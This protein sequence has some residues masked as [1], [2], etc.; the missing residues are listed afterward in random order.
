MR[1]LL[2]IAMFLAGAPV[3]TLAILAAAQWAD[4]WPAL[5]GIFVSLI[6]AGVFAL[7]WARDLDLLTEAVRRVAS[8]DPAPATQADTAVLMDTLGREIERLSRRLATRAALQEQY[9]RADTV[10]LER[11]PDPVLVLAQ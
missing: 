9:R 11:L 8:E 4:V 10:I 7:V 3:V 6:S 5:V 1:R 2:G